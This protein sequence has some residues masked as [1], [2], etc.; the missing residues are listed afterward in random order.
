VTRIPLS[1]VFCLALPLSAA[2]QAENPVRWSAAVKAREP[3]KAGTRFDVALTAKIEDGWHLYSTTQPPGGPI[4]TRITVPAGSVF[5]LAGPADGP[6]PREAFDPNFS[7]ETEFYD[8]A[9]VFTVPI[10][11]AAGAAAGVQE[12]RI[13]AYFQ[14]CDDRFCLPPRTER[15]SLRVDVAGTRGAVTA[16]EGIAAAPA[17]TSVVSP[18]PTPTA[19]PPSAPAA[20]AS[21]INFDRSHPSTLLAF[22]ALAMSVGALSLL[23][24]CVFPMIPIT[25]SYFTNHAAGNRRAAVRQAL[26]YCGGIV[27]TFTALGMAL[28]L[29]AGASGLNRFAANP[30][31]NLLITAIFLAFAASLFGRFDLALPASM[32]SRL[33]GLARASG[34]GTLPTLLMGLTFTLTSFTCTAP[35]IGTLLVTAAQGEWQWP[36]VGML[37]FSTVFA[38]PF[39]VLALTPHLLAQLPRAGEWTNTVKV[40]MGFL[41]VAAAI[42]FLSNVDLVWH[43]SVFTREVV[44]ALWTIIAVGLAAYLLA[45]LRRRGPLGRRTVGRAA[46]AAPVLAVA[47]FLATGLAGRRLGELEAF[48]PPATAEGADRAS[49]TLEGELPWIVNDYDAARAAA[50]RSGRLILIDFTGYTCTNCRWMEANM[51]PRDDVRRELEPYVRVRLYTDGE[52]DVYARHQEFQAAMFKTV[53]LPYYAIMTSEGEAVATFAGLTREPEYFIAFLRAPSTR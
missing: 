11:V 15:L 7:M 48:L 19:P 35:F 50:A 5:S 34:G 45:G 23:T 32:V 24:P 46:W 47:V 52:G 12:L 1:I 18:A 27:L 8:E 16:G 31:I 6:P 3:V 20:S 2:A 43:W 14:T 17:A 42:K 22:I 25:V 44:L 26:V 37:A 41:E 53:A 38:L 36:L 51:F 39:F 40:S 49:G 33:D 13:H 30:W 29:V 4:A 10:R 28:A 9:V 21:P